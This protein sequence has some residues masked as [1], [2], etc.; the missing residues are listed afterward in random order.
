M[1]VR[2]SSVRED[3]NSWL[4]ENKSG[5]FDSCVS[6]FNILYAMFS[7]AL[8]D[9]LELRRTG[10]AV[11]SCRA[12]GMIPALCSRLASSLETLLISLSEHAR[13]FGTIPNIVPLSASNFR[14]ARERAT[15]RMSDLLSDV[16]FTRRSRFLHKIETLGHMAISIRMHF[17]EVATDIGSGA[18]LEPSADWRAVDDA[19]YDLNTCLRETIVLLKSFLVILPDEQ[20]GA[21]QKSVGSLL[22][23]HAEESVPV[24]VANRRR[25]IAIERQ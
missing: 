5:V 2:N 10:R 14:G 3:W 6:Q 22:D 11:Q 21:F 9:A 17:D 23:N 7:V 1:V 20:L 15:A 25:L 18:S 12:I 24:G 16:L 4:P 8:N 13:H 19:H